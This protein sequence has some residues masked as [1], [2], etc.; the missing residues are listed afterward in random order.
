MSGPN[1]Q[2]QTPPLSASTPPK[3][4]LAVLERMA[5]AAGL[6]FDE[7]KAQRALRQVEIDIPPT[8]T[9]ASRER[10]SKAAQELGLV[11][12][13]RQLSV[14]EAVA[15]AEPE[16]P[17]AIFAVGP[18]GTARW[19]VLVDQ[20]GGRGRLAQLLEQ[21]SD[22]FLSVDDLARRI[23]AADADAVVEWL[24]AQAATPWSDDS[25]RPN[26]VSHSD[27]DAHHGPRP[28]TRLLRLL[29]SERRDL[30]LVVA[31]AI[32]VGILSLATP[33]TAMAVVNTVALA[34][35]VQQLI[36][37][38]LAL[39]VSLGLAAL[40]QA[41]QTVVV[42]YIQRRIF[43]RVAADLAFRLPRVDLK[44]FDKQHGPELV[45]RF[46]DVLTVQK[47]SATLLLDGVAMVLQTCIGLALLS[48]YHQ[49]LLG[50]DLALIGGLAFIVFVL[51]RG[52][53]NTA[54][55]ES[56][57]KY[58][59]AGWMEEIARHSVAFKLSGGP[60]F[61]QERTDML[62]RE[63][64]LAR[65]QHFRIVLRQFVFGLSLQVLASTMLLGMGGYL[66][67]NGQMTLGQLVAAQIVVSLVV[68]SIVKFGKQL[69][70]YYDLLAAVEKLGHLT[71]VPL[72]R[73]DGVA[74]QARTKGVALNVRDLRF[75][76]ENGHRTVL[77]QFSLRVEPGERVALI[78]PNG[79]GKSTLV[80]L[81][82]GLRNPIRGHIEIDGMDLR[83]LRL[84][85]L[86]EHVAIVKGVEIFEGSVLDNLR[87]GR[88]ELSIA[89]VRQALRT[90]GLLDEVL[91]LRDGLKTRL[92]TG[93]APLSLGQT[94]RLMLARAIAGKPRL[95]VLDET[96]DDMDQNV[97]EEVLP[98]VLGREA[99]WTLLV[100]THSREVASLCD[101]QV[102]I[103]RI[104]H[105]E[106][107]G[108]THSNES[109]QSEGNS[110]C[111]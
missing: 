29:R 48:S 47:S 50:F 77:D 1:E 111:R 94:E 44:A 54:L 35:L 57:A 22:D 66:V 63:Y 69:E 102:Q 53:V 83:D 100:I 28:F 76:Y 98:A 49:I 109:D 20:Q 60:R 62:A 70:S 104:R 19:H 27:A 45:N 103:E 13:T 59:V 92:R 43:V 81:L 91:D 72:E 23:D 8:A 110:Q 17:L 52:A 30:W 68:V 11:I 88:E 75:T 107:A 41:L 55:G 24:I 71:D 42:E 3:A 51:G 46:F 31:Y 73:D 87:M 21:D 82:F 67:I 16:L 78:G 58:A 86:R 15:A 99:L 96:L 64:L 65:Q 93:G 26:D 5:R 89:D 79:T 84:E 85:S 12:L 6:P 95:L 37:L 32:G 39:F 38:C 36:V 10:L 105:P 18:D 80:D 97:R 101:R 56:R 2:A 4:I 7:T 33:I 61:A 90:V 74:H 34:T 25:G 108:N 14:R 106:R 9:R 40:L